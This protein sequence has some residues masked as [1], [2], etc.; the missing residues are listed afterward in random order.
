MNEIKRK[1]IIDKIPSWYNP[2]L[3]AI[4]P[5]CIGIFIIIGC[6]FY[7]EFLTWLSL[8][9]IPITL[10]FLF[11]FEWV[12]HRY[13]LHKRQ[14]L[15]GVIYELHELSHHVIYT[16]EEMSI[17]EKKELYY[18][19]MPPYAILIVF[20]LV[21]PLAFGLGLLFSL[22]VA[23]LIIITA[24]VFFLC[25]EWLHFSYHQPANTWIGRN[26]TIRKLRR[27]HRFHHNPR[28]MKKY[29]F[30]VTIPIFD[31]ILGTYWR[32]LDEP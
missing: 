22:N 9:T 2:Y 29:N 31:L 23:C 28:L 14:P 11:G 16:D 1:Q 32:K 18:V 26:R 17:R 8:L 27:L 6:L 12:T 25:Y 24:M 30:N 3:H 10:F 20:C 15:L 4:I 21:A 13:V 19:L 7:I 5:S